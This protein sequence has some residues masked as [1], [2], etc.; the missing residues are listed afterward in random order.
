M[1]LI[2]NPGGFYVPWDSASAF[3]NPDSGAGHN[4]IANAGTCTLAGQKVTATLRGFGFCA[5]VVIYSPTCP[6]NPEF[7]C[8]LPFS[9]HIWEPSRLYITCKRYATGLNGN[10][11]QIVPLT[12]IAMN[13]VPK[14]RRTD[15]TTIAATPH[16]L[17]ITASGSRPT[18]GS[19]AVTGQVSSMTGS[20]AAGNYLRLPYDGYLIGDWRLMTGDC[21]AFTS[22][23]VTFVIMFQCEADS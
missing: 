6:Q 9:F 13:T 7:Y 22:A 4:V 3:D 17:G 16:L 2:T 21:S 15:G 20:V 11:G 14:H 8:N 18:Y 5:V 12:Q 10:K 19:P 23:P 1:Q